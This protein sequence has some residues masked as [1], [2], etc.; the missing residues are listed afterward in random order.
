M[1]MTT[2]KAHPPIYYTVRTVVRTALIVSIALLAFFIGRAMASDPYEYECNGKTVMAD[3]GDSLWSL[4]QE[5]C[6]GHIGKAVHDLVKVY[7][8]QVKYGEYVTL[9]GERK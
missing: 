6:T 7:G 3:N 2:H 8:V 5:N 4:A 1:S 9:D